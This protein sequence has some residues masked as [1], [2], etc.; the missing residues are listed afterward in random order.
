MNFI[1]NNITL[2]SV[3][4]L[5]AIIFICLSVFSSSYSTDNKQLISDIENTQ[6]EI[7]DHRNEI[8][9]YIGLEFELD[10]AREDLEKLALLEREQNRLW[11]SVL[12]EENNL[13]EN[14]KNKDS[15]SVNSTL[16]RQFSQ[17]RNLCKEKYVILPGQNNSSPS[18][19]FLENTPRPTSEFGF[20]FRAYDGNWPNF[21]EEESQKL[22]IQMAI[23][24]QIVEYLSKSATANHPLSL[25][26]ILRESVGPIDERNIGVDKLDLSQY[27]KKLL[28]THK[29]VDSMCFEITFIGKTSNARTFMNQLT[30]PYLL[31]DF[32][33][34]RDTSN[35]SS[36]LLPGANG[37][38]SPNSAIDENTEVPIVQEVKSKYVFLVEYITELERD[39]EKFFKDTLNHDSVDL[40]S[41][42]SFLEKSGHSKMVDHLIQFI[43]DR[44]DS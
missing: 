24:K 18:A 39:H 34:N 23:I 25:V 20:G 27:N 33:A 38:T 1:K 7:N 35:N 37:F 15:E 29:I 42:K 26:R 22:G 5:S 4:L 8:S 11:N 6:E 31:R 13:S 28:K 14:W 16:I 36:S 40:E 32:F 41:L 21:S 2:M 10:K 12:F 17:L 9:P 44:D 43:K 30:P 19:P 3:L